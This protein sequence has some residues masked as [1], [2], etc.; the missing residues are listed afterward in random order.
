MLCHLCSTLLLNVNSCTPNSLKLFLIIT[1]CT[2]YL[3]HLIIICSTDSSSW[4]H[5]H[6]P[7]SCFP[8]IFSD[9]FRA[10]CPSLNLVITV[11]SL[12]CPPPNLIIFKLFWIWYKCLPFSSLS[13]LSCQIW[14]VFS[15][16]ILLTSALLILI[17]ISIFPFFKALF[18]NSSTCSFPFTPTWAGTHINCTCPPWFVIL[19]TDFI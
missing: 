16:M 5:S 15:Q 14:L 11:S 1:L 2:S 6:K 3:L 19:V 7:V 17:C 12:L 8:I 9:L 18:A 13:H 4:H 10:P